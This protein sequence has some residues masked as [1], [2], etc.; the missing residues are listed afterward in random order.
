[1][2]N[3]IFINVR[4]QFVVFVYVLIMCATLKVHM[5]TWPFLS[6][7][8]LIALALSAVDIQSV[9]STPVATLLPGELI[10]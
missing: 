1:M 5:K 8:R 7:L 9:T 10:I 2:T 3:K 6:H 4:K